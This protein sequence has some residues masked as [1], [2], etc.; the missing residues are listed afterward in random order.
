MTRNLL[1]QETSPYL[2]QHK[3]NPVHWRPW[4]PEALADAAAADKPILLSIGYAACHWCHVMAHESFEDD[5]LAALMNEFFINIKVD[6]EERPDIDAIYQTALALLG[7][8]GGWPLTMFL[9]PS[10]EPFWGGTYFPDTPRYGHPGFGDVLVQI[11]EVYASDSETVERNRQALSE[12]LAKIAAQSQSGALTP[13]QVDAIA[14]EQL[15]D[16]DMVHG[17]TTGAPKF[18]RPFLFDFL[19]CA[20]LRGGDN[21]FADAVTLSLNHICQGGI[22]DH[23]A[24]GFA[25]YA[26]DGAWLVPHFEKMLYDNALLLDTLSLVWRH[27]GDQLY[28][29]RLRET[30]AWALDDMRAANGAFAA[31]YDADSEGEEGKFCIWDRAEILELLGEGAEDFCRAYGVT[32]SGNFEGRNILNRLDNISL[33]DTATESRLAEQRAV[34]LAARRQR[35]PPGWDDKVLA[36]WNGLMIAAL[37]NAGAVFHET[38]WTTAAAEAYEAIVRDLSQSDARL[39]HSWRG[40]RAAHDGVLDDYAN[41]AR[42]ALV[43]FEVLGGDDYLTQAEAWADV[44]EAH[45]LDARSGGY[46]FTADDAEGL[47]TRTR[48]AAD[49]ATPAGNGILVSVLAKLHQ[50]TG[51]AVYR[52]RAEKLVAA[53]AGAAG[54]AQHLTSH[55]FLNGFLDFADAVDVVIV[56]ARGED[57]TNELLAAAHR[58]PL[59]DRALLVVTPD[60]DLPDGHPAFGRGQQDGKAT[61]YICRGQTCSLP[62]TDAEALSEALAPAAV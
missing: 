7:K 16:M 26:V 4:G 12:S 25:R 2:L 56:G 44:L 52:E 49:S 21:R 31:S 32:E 20:Y 40:G 62:L 14:L 38:A 30:I 36:D 47:I 18:P 61:A 42:A 9:T 23:L 39:L 41:M 54:G 10:G 46:F 35:V 19:W 45:F 11:H 17:G 48:S 34:L 43:L 59:A 22:Y 5:R 57:G 29:T 50:L 53:F 51:K 3:D 8:Q 60:H 37:A 1:D 27:T 13:E 15:G 55:A 33:G 24:G 28:E 58:A 6:R